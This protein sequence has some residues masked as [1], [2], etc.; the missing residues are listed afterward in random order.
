M[1]GKLKLLSETFRNLGR[2]VTVDYPAGAW[3]GTKHGQA[4][5][6]LR[7]RLRFNPE[8][9]VGCGACSQACTS[10]ANSFNDEAGKRTV[11][12]ALGRC[13]FCGRCR[14]ICPQEALDQTPEFELAYMDPGDTEL[15]EV[16]VETGLAQCA[17]CGVAFAPS[18]QIEAVKERVLKNIDPSERERVAADLEKY[19]YYCPNCRRRMSYE[20]DTHPRRYY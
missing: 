1:R 7:G 14:E 12:I 11:R 15:T 18:R 2:P 8:K 9:C 16:K 6:G 19:S 17:S 3:P 5:P 4:P 20:W 13:I 10:G